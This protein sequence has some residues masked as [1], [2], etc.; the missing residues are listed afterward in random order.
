E[1]SGNECC[2]PIG[3]DGMTRVIEVGILGL[4]AGCFR[5]KH[6]ITARCVCVPGAVQ[7]VP[8][9]LGIGQGPS[10]L[11]APGV[12]SHDEDLHRL[13]LLN[14]VLTVLQPVIIPTNMG[15]REISS[16]GA[17]QE[18]IIMLWENTTKVPV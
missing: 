18:A 12:G 10:V 5:R 17:R 6:P 13:L 4:I 15:P 16:F 8:A 3:R 1:C 11:L 14:T 7:V 9:E 2:T